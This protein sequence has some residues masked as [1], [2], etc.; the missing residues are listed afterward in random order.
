MKLKILKWIELIKQVINENK[1]LS[2]KIIAGIIILITILVIVSCSNKSENINIFANSY[3]N[4]LAVQ[5]GKWIY[6]VEIDDNEQV[7]ICKIKTNGKKIE[8]VAQGEMSNLNIIGN[9]IYCIEYDEDEEQFN[10][11]KIKTNGKN[12]EILARDIQRDT[13]VAQDKWVFYYKN[14]N[15][16][17]VKLNGTDREKIS[18]KSIS[19]YT[20]E[21][22]WIYYIYKN[23]NTQYIA[24]MKLNG[25]NAE[26]IAKADEDTH[27]ETLY[28]K[29]GKIYYIV[30]E[31][32]DKNDTEYYLNRM[33]KKGEKI[34]TICKLDD[35]IQSIN[36]QE[37]A[38]YYVETEDY[39]SYVIKSIKYNGTDRKTIENEELVSSVNVVENWIIYFSMNE[40]YDITMKMISLDG[41][42]E[43]YL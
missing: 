12:K 21:G 41:E 1:S 23:N 35:N 40:D 13:V 2:M 34:K 38:I 36:M 4:G 24:K 16:Y 32:N 37:N 29:N 42:K 31:Y 15:L 39:D 10:L 26:R 22:N 25:E 8:K 43:K 17:R 6:Y 11:I 7:G 30:S 14:D 3:N 18:D 33:N 19:Y 9:Y 28:I 5:D 27:F 20:I